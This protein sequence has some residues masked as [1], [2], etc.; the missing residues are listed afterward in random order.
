MSDKQTP[1]TFEEWRKAEY[2]KPRSSIVSVEE[3]WNAAVEVTRAEYDD[4]I[5]AMQ[6]EID[7]LNS[8]IK[9]GCIDCASHDCS[10]IKRLKEVYDMR[11]AIIDGMRRVLAV[12]RMVNNQR[13]DIRMTHALN[14]YDKYKLKN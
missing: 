6:A 9:H 12:S 2:Q 11:G 10:E 3:T 8:E 1:K 13:P 4:K 5:K 14:D 7:K